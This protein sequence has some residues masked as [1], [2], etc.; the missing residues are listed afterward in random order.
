MEFRSCTQPWFEMQLRYNSKHSFCCFHE[1][2][3]F[4]SKNFNVTEMW[5]NPIYQKTRSEIISNNPTNTRCEGCPFITYYA[6]PI[7]LGIPEFVTGDRRAN[8][9]QAIKHYQNNDTVLES[10]PVKYFLFFGLACNLRCKMCDH[11]MR[12]N[13]GENAFFDPT[14][15]LENPKYMGLASKIDVIGGEPFLIPTAVQFI[16]T[17][18]QR[19]DIEGL[20]V[21]IYTNG[22]MLDRFIERLSPMN[23]LHMVVSLDS[24]GKHFEEIRQRAS[25]ERIEKNMRAF[26]A[27]GKKIGRNWR[28]NIAVTVMKEGILGYPDLV[29]YAIELGQS[30][31]FAPVASHTPGARQQYIF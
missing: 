5:N 16:D 18:V 19:S 15:L 22:M 31:H 25:W 11:P 12:F 10:L 30:I 24:Y 26:L 13:A 2:Q 4:D 3:S 8:W 28:T 6:D 27:H 17:L 9:E 23:H 20:E 21:A 14:A 7:F 1:D 29:N